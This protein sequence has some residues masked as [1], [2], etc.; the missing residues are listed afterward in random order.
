VPAA[1]F[2]MAPGDSFQFGLQVILDGLEAQLP[3]Q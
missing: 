3:G 2:G 1:A